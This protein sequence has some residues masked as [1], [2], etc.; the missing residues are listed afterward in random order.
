MDGDKLASVASW[1]IRVVRRK[2]FL[3]RRPDNPILKL[4]TLL[5]DNVQA[6]SDFLDYEATAIRVAFQLNKHSL[7]LMH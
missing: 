7:N 2:S 5:D 4:L 6:M 3:R 1:S